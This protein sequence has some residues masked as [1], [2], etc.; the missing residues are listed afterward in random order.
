MPVEKCDGEK[1]KYPQTN[2]DSV[3]VANEI[4]AT[5]NLVTPP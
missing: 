2:S 5:M 3:S 4:V 1:L